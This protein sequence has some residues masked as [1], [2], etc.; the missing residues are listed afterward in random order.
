M[1]FGIDELT[2]TPHFSEVTGR[3]GAQ[4]APNTQL[5]LGVNWGLS[6]MRGLSRFWQETVNDDKTHRELG[7]ASSRK[8]VVR[9]LGGSL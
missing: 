7:R 1:W 6:H 8:F 2:L 5:Q 4:P 3:R 9:P